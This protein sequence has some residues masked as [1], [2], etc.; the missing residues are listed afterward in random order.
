MKFGRKA[1]RTA[2]EAAG[3]SRQA[4]YYLLKRRPVGGESLLVAASVIKAAR[5]TGK[6]PQEVL[7]AL[8]NK[9][10]VGPWIEFAFSDR[11]R[12]LYSNGLTWPVLLSFIAFCHEKGVL[13]GDARRDS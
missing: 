7:V 11:T 2:A 13:H 4:I 12:T 3:C 10:L 5:K 8:L 9:G 1:V 6:A